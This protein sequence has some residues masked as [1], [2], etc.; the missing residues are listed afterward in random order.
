MKESIIILLSLI[1][2]KTFGQ[3]SD[4]LPHDGLRNSATSN[5]VDNGNLISTD[6]YSGTANVN[7]SVYSY[8]NSSND[9]SNSVTLRYDASGVKANAISSDVGLNWSI[10]VGGYVNRKVIGMPDDMNP[11]ALSNN[12]GGFSNSSE[13][14]LPNNLNTTNL[15]EY[16][17]GTQ[18]GEFDIFNYKAGE[19]S[20]SFIISKDGNIL[21]IPKSNVIIEVIPNPN[22]VN[23]F[24]CH[25][26]SFKIILPNGVKY[27]YENS[28]CQ[29]FKDKYV[30]KNSV[31]WALSKIQSR[32]NN[33][34]ILFNSIIENFEYQESAKA[35]YTNL[36][37]NI[38]YCDLY[39]NRNEVKL[40]YPYVKYLQITYPNGNNVN[41]EYDQMN[42]RKDLE[43]FVG[44]LNHKRALKAIDVQCNYPTIGS[45]SYGYQLEH[46]YMLIGAGDNAS[47]FVPY[48]GPFG[49]NDDYNLM[50]SKLYK[51]SG[52]LQDEP[53]QFVYSNQ[54]SYHFPNDRIDL[55][56]YFTGNINNPYTTYNLNGLSLA[57][58]NRFPN[59]QYTKAKSLEKIITPSGGEIE[60]Q[61][62]LHTT[63][64]NSLPNEKN[65]T[66]IPNVGGLRIKKIVSKDGVDN[67]NSIVKEFKYTEVNGVTS[68]GVMANFPIHGYEYSETNDPNS[69]YNGYISPVSVCSFYQPQNQTANFVFRNNNP[70][71]T[72]IL[73][74]GK[75]VGYG[76]VEE[77]IGSIQNHIQKNVYT[78]STSDNYPIPAN[79]NVN[80]LPFPYIPNNDF[81]K[82]LLLSE[83]NYT[84]S[85]LLSSEKI[86]DYQTSMEVVTF[87]EYKGF[88]AAINHYPPNAVTDFNY[89]YVYPITGYA[90][91]TKTTSKKYF[92]AGPPIED[93]VE[94]T[95]DVNN[96]VVRTVKTKDSKNEI[97]EKKFYY[98]FD[99]TIAGAISQLNTEGVKYFPIV[100]ETWKGAGVNAKL[101]NAHANT[102]Q[103]GLSGLRQ[104]KAY[105]YTSSTPVNQATWGSFNQN[106][107]LQ[108]P[109]LYTDVVTFDTYDDKGNLTHLESFGHK[110]SYKWGY[111]KHYIIIKAENANLEDVSYTSFEEGFG[112][113]FIQVGNNV[114]PNQ[115]NSVMGRF[116]YIINSNTSIVKNGLNAQKNYEVTLWARNGPPIITANA[117]PVSVSASETHNGWTLYKS[118][119]QNATTVSITSSQNNIIDEIRLC[120][121]GAVVQTF[122]FDPLY[123]NVISVCD[124]GHKIIYY[125]YDLLGR[126]KLV[127]NMDMNILNM[128]EYVKHEQQ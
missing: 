57:G 11:N 19:Y 61:F 62:E 100:T 87:P 83:K 53:Y 113:D 115:Q 56:G 79:L 117:L 31:V 119:I 69:S 34:E 32:D 116:S 81:L 22:P 50:L 111:N 28:D 91:L 43:N 17:D 51:Y 104:H 24:V 95:Y 4:R 68:S 98:P 47:N 65:I 9:L 7:I 110:K 27:Y 52:T 64:S 96:L 67:L 30:T 84:P 13:V 12:P 55:W 49:N 112:D 108:N 124:A 120:P 40:N 35:A 63:K 48:T 77:Y 6:L 58:D 71:N 86:F 36:N 127:R 102:F 38:N 99:Y 21:Q 59:L 80:T 109:S 29:E 123:G 16:S 70:L 25:S 23:I 94:N 88:K 126:L 39:Q 106:T 122:A 72:L 74:H 41:F 44:N 107:L 121:I 54:S 92:S 114:I 26:P 14:P 1:T 118:K 42:T 66:T 125:E 97:L 15:N 3:V 8:K 73:T 60:L 89:S 33:S 105:Q 37:S 45:S 128:S 20:G 75:P 78:F 85:G 46:K 82:G 93:E 18:D 2:I 10:D 101:I 90:L 103:I 5:F 76:R